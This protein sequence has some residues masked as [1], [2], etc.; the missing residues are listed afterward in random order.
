MIDVRTGAE[1]RG[2]ARG[3]AAKLDATEGESAC[4]FIESLVSVVLGVHASQL[5]SD[6]RGPAAV[7]VARQAAMYLAHVCLG[8]CL[9]R[10]GEQFGR[11]RTT[12]AYACARMEDRRDNPYV[13]RV[14]ACLEAALDRWRRGAIAEDAP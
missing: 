1:L 5:S 9:S 6:R 7:A 14:L 8:M 4:R 11:D 10:V 3:N 12:V 2:R 13:D